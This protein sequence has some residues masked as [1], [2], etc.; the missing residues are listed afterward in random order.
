M[1][2]GAQNVPFSL[3]SPI[4]YLVLFACVVCECVLAMIVLTYRTHRK[5]GFCIA[6]AF[7]SNVLFEGQAPTVRDCVWLLYLRYTIA[8]PLLC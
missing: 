7:G 1:R 4:Q 8:T 2:S 6:G 3:P 5:G